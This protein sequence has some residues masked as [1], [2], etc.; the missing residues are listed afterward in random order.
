M[1]ERPFEA[2]ARGPFAALLQ[3]PVQ[4]YRWDAELTEGE[5]Q[6]GD[7][8]WLVAPVPVGVPFPARQYAPLAVPNLHRRFARLRRTPEA[9]LKF[10]NRYGLLGHGRALLVN[11]PHD[12]PSPIYLGESLRFWQDGIATLAPLLA[13]WDLVQRGNS[14]ALLPYVRW[15][16]ESLAVRIQWAWSEKDGL[17]PVARAT[18]RDARRVALVATEARGEQDRSLLARWRYG[19][20]VEPARY[21][22]C[23]QVNERL[24]GHVSPAVLPLRKGEVYFFPDC[25]RSAL[26]TH[27]LLEVSGRVRPAMLCARPGCGRYFTPTHGR[28][29]HCS[30]ECRRLAYYYRHKKEGT[31][32]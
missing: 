28:Q 15:E 22:V 13:L 12:A 5:P 6:D 2:M 14:L 1:T 8:Q 25:L 18:E 9:V 29:R 21:W 3:V 4:G 30:G 7:H 32:G 16:R 17:L 19:D 10:A 31:N 24:R 23:E 11:S 26:Y 20:T 27:L